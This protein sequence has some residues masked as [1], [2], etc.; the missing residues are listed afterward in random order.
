LVLSKILGI[1]TAEHN[2]KQV[3]KIRYRDHA[4]LGNKVTAK[5]TNVYGQYQQVK[6]CNMD[7]QRSSVGR[8]WTEEDLH[9]MKMDVFCADIVVLLDTNARIQNIRTF[10][11]WNKVWQQPLKG[12]GPRG[13][14]VLEERLKKIFLGIKLIYNEKLFWIHLVKF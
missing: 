11:N 5:I 3:K 8:L 4:N 12:V 7:D 13:D 1:G 10:C 14:A 6:L 9:C 2:W